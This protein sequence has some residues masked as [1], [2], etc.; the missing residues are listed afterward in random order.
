MRAEACP[1]RS[2]FALIVFLSVTLSRF[3]CEM[4]VL[5]QVLLKQMTCLFSILEFVK[6]P[7]VVK[8][9]Q[10][11]ARLQASTSDKVP[12]SGWLLVWV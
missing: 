12:E 1:E 9:A 6:K 4:L 7:N 2:L 10:C 8:G 3:R 11:G 5:R